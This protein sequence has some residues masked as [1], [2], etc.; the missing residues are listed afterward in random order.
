MKIFRVGK[1]AQ[2]HFFNISDFDL[3]NELW[4]RDC[5]G[6]WLSAKVELMS[7]VKFYVDV[8]NG[9]HH[10]IMDYMSFGPEVVIQVNTNTNK[11]ISYFKNAWQ[12]IPLSMFKWKP[13][14]NL[15]CNLFNITKIVDCFNEDESQCEY[16]S[17]G[18]RIMDIKRYTFNEES[19]PV[20]TSFF[21]IP[22]VRG[23]DVMLVAWID[24][25]EDDFYFM[26]HKLWL[27]GLEFK[28][29][30]RTPWE[31]DYDLEGTIEAMNNWEELDKSLYQKWFFDKLF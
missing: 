7:G 22:N 1:E 28:E 16:F 5:I 15:Q 8:E 13:F 23:K 21:A 6:M 30:Y 20:W 17:D 19:I 11:L 12:V 14:D 29:I 24:K 26:Y 18:L 2:T 9:P 3:Y 10:E 4:L 31:K 25:L 27:T